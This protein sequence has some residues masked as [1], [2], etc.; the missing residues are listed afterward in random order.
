M[1]HLTFYSNQPNLY[2]SRFP[3]NISAFPFEH[4]KPCHK[5]KPIHLSIHK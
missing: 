3:L 1:M 5:S 2:Q 4:I